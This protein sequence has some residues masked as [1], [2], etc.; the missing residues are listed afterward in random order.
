MNK[1]SSFRRPLLRMERHKESSRCRGIAL[2][3][4]L[5]ACTGRPLKILMLRYLGPLTTRS[6]SV[7]LRCIHRARGLCLLLCLNSQLPRVSLLGNFGV[8]KIDHT[9]IVYRP[10]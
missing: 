5:R 10:E 3:L 7:K 4:G 1:T 8:K 9:T 6:Q 2:E